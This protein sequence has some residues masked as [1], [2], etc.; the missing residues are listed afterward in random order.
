MYTTLVIIYRTLFRNTLLASHA[1][2]PYAGSLLHAPLLAAWP[3]IL[4][5]CNETGLPPALGRT[6]GSIQRG[7]YA[8]IPA[9]PAGVAT[10][11]EQSYQKPLSSLPFRRWTC[12]SPSPEASSYGP[13]CI[14][15][16]RATEIRTR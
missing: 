16:T 3:G 5:S 2:L 14:N 7:A 13:T 9:T 12:Y 11:L 15:M 1:V 10:E 4:S 8:R 6:G